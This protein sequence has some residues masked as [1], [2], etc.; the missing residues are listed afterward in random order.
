MKTAIEDD[1]ITY[2]K[3]W[4]E[5]DRGR[6]NSWWENLAQNTGERAY[7]RRCATPAEGIIS[8]E[9]YRLGYE[10]GWLWQKKEALATIAVMLALIKEKNQ[11]SFPVQL[12]SSTKGDK[13]LMSEARFRHLL[14]ARDWDD[15][16]TALRRGLALA[17]YTANPLS[18]A[19]GILL[20]DEEKRSGFLPRMKNS[21]RFEWSSQYYTK[22][23]SQQPPA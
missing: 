15:F 4:K 22:V 14:T 5:D 16:F 2:H 9:T 7:L 13:P 17:K 21:F 23:F 6:I 10:I 19:D 12:G 11:R 1:K 3:L 18:I 20:W 8:K